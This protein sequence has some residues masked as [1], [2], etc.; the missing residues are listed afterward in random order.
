VI[1]GVKVLVAL[2]AAAAALS[3]A[4]AAL[5][6]DCGL[7]DS[8]PLWVDFA[9]HDAP[10]PA[11]PGMVLA[12]ASGTDVPAQMRAAGAATVLFDLNFNKRVGTTSN[13][14]DPSLMQ[15]RAKSL[16][17]YAVSV[18]GCQTPMIAENELAG[19]QTPTPW[20]STNGQYRANVLAFLTALQAL[21]ARP[22][23]S[24]ANPPYTA[25]DD[26]KEWWRAV[27]QVA[28]LLRQVYFTSPNALGLYAQGPAKASRSIRQ[29]LRG[30]V[31]HLTQI[32]IPASRVAL[33]MQFNLATRAA[34]QPASAWL[35]IVKLEA[36]AA[37][38]VV[39]EYKING[40]WSWGWATFSSDPSAVDP[41]KPAAACVWLWVRDPNLCDAPN[42]AGSFDTSLTEGQ[43]SLPPGVRCVFPDGQIDRNAVSRLT[44]LT[45][46]AG[47]AASVLLEQAVLK[48]EHAVQPAQLLSAERAVIHSSFGGDRKRYWAGLAQ[49][50][51]TI[52]DAR[53]IIAARLEHDDVEARF[54]P[55]P[56]TSA[57]I[58]DFL[59]TYAEQPAR[60][61]QTTRSAPWLGGAKKGWAVSTLAPSEVFALDD[62]GTIDTPDGPF[63][64]SPLGSAVPLALVPHVQAVEAARAVLERLARDAVYRSWL[65]DAEQKQ[66]DAASC[67]GD[68]MPT[69]AAT[70]L[71]AFV[72]FLLPS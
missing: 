59:A 44:R 27:S 13:P 33:E 63:D 28:V 58:A 18:T 38:E 15:A 20:S 72:P 29:S 68:Q 64:V 7:P 14:A 8:G 45:G 49:A 56:P 37:K 25:S 71:S 51:L 5:A 53:A 62:A 46:D 4:P 32:G 42:D 57:Q 21:G 19:A 26:A 11:K 52:A 24:I 10:I 48:A 35:E 61:V 39:K 2:L 41:D 17:D 23:L 43:L 40:V 12:V 69:P 22:L 66:L 31:N 1:C 6:D 60:L 3:G 55:R 36:L 30:L 9:G 70:D 65:H 34:L 50:K 54:R 47:Y 67:A 16:Y